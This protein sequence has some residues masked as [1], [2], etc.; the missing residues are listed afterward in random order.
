MSETPQV[1]SYGAA[2]TVTGSC[3][4]LDTG[5]TNVLVDCGAFQ[6]SA[7]LGHLNHEPFGFD[8]AAIDAV[9]LTHAHMDHAARLPLLVK[10]GY[11]GPIYALRATKMLAE[12]L[13]LDGAKIQAEDAARDKRHGRVPEEPLFDEDD[14]HRALELFEE[15]HY[16][17]T[18]QVAGLPVTPPES[19][20]RRAAGAR[21]ASWWPAA[22][23]L[24]PSSR[25]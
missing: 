5:S 8:L 12:H 9:L 14:V 17:Q 3:H 22:R 4:L 10:R 20:P 1:R 7:A 21:R 13:L 15:V 6:G 25:A 24:A 2:M 16:G 19:W 18:T 11:S 23:R